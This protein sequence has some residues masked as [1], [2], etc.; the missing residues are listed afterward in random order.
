MRRQRLQRRLRT[1]LNRGVDDAQSFGSFDECSKPPGTATKTLRARSFT[2]KVLEAAHFWNIYF[3]SLAFDPVCS[4]L[5]LRAWGP[6][7]RAP[8]TCV[9]QY[10]ATLPP[11]SGKGEG[12]TGVGKRERPRKRKTAAG[13]VAEVS[14]LLI[15]KCFMPSP[16]QSLWW[17]AVWKKRHVSP[18]APTIACEIDCGEYLAGRTWYPVCCAPSLSTTARARTGFVACLTRPKDTPES[19]VQF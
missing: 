13:A 18:Q 19:V 14:L 6:C 15:P 11:R 2:K 12:T 5:Y 7:A 1:P 16:R 8:G 9:H 4:T 10:I 17:V 3:G